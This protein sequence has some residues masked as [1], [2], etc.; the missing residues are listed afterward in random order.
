M[1]VYNQ[2]SMG[3]KCISQY[4][5]NKIYSVKLTTII[6]QIKIQEHIK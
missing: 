6:S 2:M 3:E 5:Q 1:W 4:E